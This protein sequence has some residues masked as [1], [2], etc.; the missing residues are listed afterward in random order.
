MTESAVPA[1][2][3][4]TDSVPLADGLFTWPSDDP[5][6]LGSRCDTCATMT[7]PTHYGCPRC[8][9]DAMTTVE[10]G[11][12]GQV[13]TWTSQEFRP[14]PPYRGPNDFE[15]Y[16]VG[17][18][19]LPDELIVETYFTGFDDG[20]PAIGDHVELTVIPFGTTPDGDDVVTYA[21]RP[22]TT[23]DPK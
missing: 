2:S 18:V 23:G 1:T 9:S 4:R 10:L 22:T 11:T 15:A 7:F 3:P 16:Y 6:L 5:K 12:R 19:E 21:F 13:W 8:S 14:P 17:Y 20:Q